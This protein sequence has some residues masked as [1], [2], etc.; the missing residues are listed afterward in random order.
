MLSTPLVAT[1]LDPLCHAVFV[2]DRH[3]AIPVA[4][5][6][7]IITVACIV[8]PPIAVMVSYSN[9]HTIRTNTD[10]RVLSMRRKYDRNSDGRK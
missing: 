4:P 5:N 3:S 1:A 9:T 10:I 7:D 8:M 2:N 6:N